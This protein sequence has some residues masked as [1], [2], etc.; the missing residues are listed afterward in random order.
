MPPGEV[1]HQLR[2]IIIMTT[3]HMGLQFEQEGAALLR[4][5]QERLVTRDR[6]TPILSIQGRG[7]QRLARLLVN[8]A[9]AE[10][11]LAEAASFDESTRLPDGTV[12]TVLSG[13][14][15]IGDEDA[16]AEWPGYF[17]RAVAEA[18]HWLIVASERVEIELPAGI[19]QHAVVVRIEEDEEDE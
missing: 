2:Y 1:G 16:R 17:S 10:E 5:W 13:D 6:T 3:D 4:Q 14:W 8:P 18:G 7:A 12:V 11:D 15:P 9:E 19:E